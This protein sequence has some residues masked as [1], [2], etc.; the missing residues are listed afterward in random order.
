MYNIIENVEVAYLYDAKP[1]YPIMELKIPLIP[2]QDGT[3]DPSLDNIRAIEGHTKVTILVSNKEDMSNPTEYEIS[4]QSEAGDVY[5]GTVDVVNGVL[6]V[7]R[8]KV[9]LDETLTWSRYPTTGTQRGFYV[10]SVNAGI[11][12]AL[13]GLANVT[14]PFVVCDRFLTGSTAWVADRC[15]LQNKTIWFGITSDVF[16]GLDAFKEYLTDNN[17]DIVIPIEPQNYLIVGEDILTLIDDTYVTS[18]LNAIKLCKYKMKG[19]AN[20]DNMGGYILFDCGGLDLND[21]TEQT[22][23]GIYEKAQ[24]AMSK[25]K[26]VIVTNCYMGDAPCTPTSVIAWQDDADTI[27]ATGH[28]LRITIEEDDGVTVTNLVAG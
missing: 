21:S 9:T 3:G 6:T 19:E 5:G 20:M 16:E 12:N 2:I 26:P 23:D 17:I 22:I 13:P 10:T 4:L 27:V 14:A 1:I 18:N 11:S 24:A 7:D 8:V 15:G 28:V 25:G